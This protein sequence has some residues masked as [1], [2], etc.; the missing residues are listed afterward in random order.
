[1]QVSVRLSSLTLRDVTLESL[2]GSLQI[3]A[4]PL[5]YAGP[6]VKYYDSTQ[7]DP[8]ATAQ[9]IPRTSQVFRM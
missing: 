4:V 5:G 1:V 7:A 8:V 3:S 6:P 2:T 9:Q